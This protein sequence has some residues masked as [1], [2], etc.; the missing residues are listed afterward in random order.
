MLTL[1]V[2]VVFSD[3]ITNPYGDQHLGQD[4]TTP[5]WLCQ[6]QALVI[7]FCNDTSIFW[8]V[9]VA[10]FFF[11]VIALQRPKRATKLLPMF[12]LVNWGIPIG[13]VIWLLL[14]GS[15]GRSSNN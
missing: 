12:Y 2:V 5:Y 1:V 13:I 14:K 7:T 9:S 15:L 4:G 6:M 10:V 3:N 11:V 8:T